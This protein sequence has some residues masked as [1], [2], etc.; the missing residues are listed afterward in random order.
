M[1]TSIEAARPLVAVGELI[2]G[3]GICGLGLVLLIVGLVQRSR[4]GTTPQP[5]YPYPPHAPPGYPQ[6]YAPQQFGYPPPPPAA[7]PNGYPS[8]YPPP[9]ARKRGTA[10]IVVGAVLL[11]FGLL[12]VVGRLSH[13]TAAFSTGAHSTSRTTRTTSPQDPYAQTGMGLKV[14][15]CISSTAFEARMFLEASDCGDVMS[16]YLLASKGDSSATCPDGKRDGSVYSVL[17]NAETTM[18]F[19]PN[20][21]AGKCYQVPEGTTALFA[22]SAAC[23]PE[24]FKVLTRFAGADAN[25][26]P[27]GTRAIA[28][29]DPAVLYCIIP[30]SR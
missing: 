17:E 3:L 19:E 9:Q 2:G 27:D 25:S 30:A 4:S 23:G 21:V 14:G 10:L 20:M 18:C 6:G 8:P 12:G 22:Y 1:S 15:D 7:Y 28:F 16:T 11:A 26:C 13:S 29:P 5:Q 24:D